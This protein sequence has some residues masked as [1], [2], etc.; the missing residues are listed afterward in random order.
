MNIIDNSLARLENRIM[1][2]S[3]KLQ[4]AVIEKKELRIRGDKYRL[5]S[6][7]LGLIGSLF[8]LNKFRQ[9]FMSE[10]LQK[11]ELVFEKSELEKLNRVLK[12][13][14][15]QRAKSVKK[16]EIKGAGKLILIEPGNI[17]Y[18]VAESNGTRIYAKD[19]TFWSDEKFRDLLDQL[20]QSSFSQIF[21]STVVNI[22][23]VDYIKSNNLML[24]SGEEL[25]ISRTYKRNILEKIGR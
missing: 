25:K 12:G 10:R 7:L 23:H 19:K 9:R 6:L 24:K 11:E 20:P 8:V 1:Q 21:R 17:H 5:L 14:L 3:L 22:D 2:D 16:L 18:A 4:Q 15:E 13:K